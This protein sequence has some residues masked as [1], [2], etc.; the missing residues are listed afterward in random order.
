MAS[1]NVHTSKDG[2]TTYY[3][4]IRRR[5]EQTQSA[6]FPTRKDA[7]QWATMIEGQMIEGR[8]FPQRKPQH[9]LTSV[10]D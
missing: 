7:Q 2:K 1:I 3:V 6:T 5:G 10:A 9:T 8:H 4:R